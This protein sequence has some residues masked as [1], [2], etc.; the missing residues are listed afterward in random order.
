MPHSSLKSRF[1]AQQSLLGLFYK[2][3]SPMIAEVL[4]QTPLDLIVLD[5]EH[6]P[7]DPLSTDQCI[8]IFRLAGMPVL[9]RP[10]AS[11][12]EYIQYALDSGADGIL[13]PHIDSP[14][15]ARQLVQACYY[16]NGHR[17]FAGTT[18]A[19]DF[20][21]KSMQAH[22]DT[23]NNRTTVVAMLEDVHALDHIEEILAVDGIDAFFIGRAD[24]AAALGETSVLSERAMDVCGQ[25][26]ATAKRLNKCIG[27]FTP[28]V[29][30]ANYWK[31]KGVPFFFT[32]S[33]HAL[34]LQGA[35]NLAESF[36][37]GNKGSGKA[38]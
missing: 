35:A 33:D 13:A 2:T 7:F 30:D 14:D 3:P 31:A 1:S 22:L 4:A 26:V 5:A 21:R 17:G 24:L 18:R 12:P 32:S 27:M 25:I 29:D 20:G 8:A 16:G 36:D 11:R 23:S 38:R 10:P 9:V 19:A 37:M 6:A 15:K 28:G 34:L